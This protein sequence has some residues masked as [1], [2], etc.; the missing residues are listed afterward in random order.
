[1]NTKKRIDGDYYIETIN[2]GD[3]VHI[4]SNLDVDG[5]FNSQRKY[6]VY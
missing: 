6:Y 2:A 4:N 3:M 1:M 5:N